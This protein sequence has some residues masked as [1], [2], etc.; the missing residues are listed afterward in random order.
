[1]RLILRVNDHLRGEDGIRGWVLIVEGQTAEAISAMLR[2]VEQK[3][4]DEKI[5][6]IKGNV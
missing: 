5:A 2:L 3:L 1:M 4:T 6:D